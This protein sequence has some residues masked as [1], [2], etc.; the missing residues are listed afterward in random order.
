MSSS[1]A[2]DMIVGNGSLRVTSSVQLTENGLGRHYSRWGGGEKKTRKC[3][4]HI[5]NKA[6]L[7][8]G[9]KGSATGSG[10]APVREGAGRGPDQPPSSTKVLSSLPPSP[11]AET[12]G[13]G[14]RGDWGWGLSSHVGDQGL[15]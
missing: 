2:S 15:S 4:A 12:F 11:G 6:F 3:M 7:N 10:G 13:G 5:R 14:R 9:V 8:E 1:L